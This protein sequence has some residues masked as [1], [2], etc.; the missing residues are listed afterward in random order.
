[1]D[2]DSSSPFARALRGVL[3]NSAGRLFGLPFPALPK[4]VRFGL[5]GGVTA[6][7]NL[8]LLWLLKSAGLHAVIAYALAVAIAV[9][10]S[11][12]ASQHFVWRDRSLAF[13]LS[14]LARRWLTFHGC[15]AASI[16]INMG[17][18]VVARLFVPD[19][20]AAFVGIGCSTVVKFLSLD[21]LAFRDE[22]S[23]PAEA[24]VAGG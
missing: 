11:F 12:L 6:A 10:F 5:M 8:S 1:M 9:Q 13:G 3:G 7:I 14:A 22:V 18:F 21:R 16:G 24:E 2:S 20:A 17:S 19:L 23:P 15:I 4:L